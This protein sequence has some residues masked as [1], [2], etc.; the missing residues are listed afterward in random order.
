ML[1]WESGAVSFA[2]VGLCGVGGR[3]EE[4][5][6]FAAPQAHQR[7]RLLPQ[8]ELSAARLTEDIPMGWK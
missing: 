4:G 7:K 8:K 5:A 3:G 6:A 2:A 1:R